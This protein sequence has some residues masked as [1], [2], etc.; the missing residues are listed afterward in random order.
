MSPKSASARPWE[1]MVTFILLAARVRL[2][3]A[4]SLQRDLVGEQALLRLELLLQRAQL[5]VGAQ[6]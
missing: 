5:Q 2:E 6:E 3:R 4:L 1:P